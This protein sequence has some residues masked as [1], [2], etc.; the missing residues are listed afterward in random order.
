MRR[1][2]DQTREGPIGREDGAA[3]RSMTR[4]L[5]LVDEDGMFPMMMASLCTSQTPIQSC[6]CFATLYIEAT[7]VIQY[8][9][10]WHPVPN[11]EV[12]ELWFW[13]TRVCC[14]IASP[15]FS[16][17]EPFSDEK[18]KAAQY[19]IDVLI[20]FQTCP[21]ISQFMARLM[22]LCMHPHWH[23]MR[24]VSDVLYI[25][26]ETMHELR[27]SALQSRRAANWG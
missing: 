23:F 20:N 2:I 15:G 27:V 3:V 24:W 12:L 1:A 26:W 9:N 17:M 10:V 18:A 25:S 14:I 5:P 8:Q 21:L 11:I 16:W 7:A 13:Q 4:T 22:C 19:L 6:C